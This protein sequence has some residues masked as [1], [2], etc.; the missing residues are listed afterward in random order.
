[1]VDTIKRHHKGNENLILREIKGLHANTTTKDLPEYLQK[2]LARLTQAGFQ[3]LNGK[4]FV[5]A[6]KDNVK[7]N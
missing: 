1:L 3:F 4:G 6:P 7:R 2:E 5:L